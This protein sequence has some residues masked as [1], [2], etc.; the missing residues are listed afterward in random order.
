MPGWI[1][2]SLDGKYA[3]P[4]SGEVIDVKTRKVLSTL[5]DEFN[6][7]IGSEKMLEV[8]LEN[9]KAVR[10]GDQFGIGRITQ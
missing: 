2:F 4:S 10:A 5:K 6:N 3:Y 7:S 1:T 9:G 8:D